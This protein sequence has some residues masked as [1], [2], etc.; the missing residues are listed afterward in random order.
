MTKDNKD[1]KT[2]SETNYEIKEDDKFV[3]GIINLNPLL[4]KNVKERIPNYNSKKISNTYD[5]LNPNF[6][7]CSLWPSIEKPSSA[8]ESH[9]YL[10]K[11][12][13]YSSISAKHCGTNDFVV[14]QET[15]KLIGY[16][17]MF[18]SAKATVV[19]PP[20]CQGEVWTVGWIQAVTKHDSEDHRQIIFNNRH[21]P[22]YITL[23]HCTNLC[24]LV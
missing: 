16:M 13:I 20:I 15:E 8:V 7:L 6:S 3:T 21:S 11:G 4:V 17:P 23:V 5:V 22:P 2:N 14:F 12:K 10:L 18:F 19:F 1:G 24:I 9:K